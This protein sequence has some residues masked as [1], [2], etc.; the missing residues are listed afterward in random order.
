MII[1]SKIMTNQTVFYH[2]FLQYTR[3]NANFVD[4]GGGYYYKINT[5]NRVGIYEIKSI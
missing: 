1:N 3:I 5:K 2:Y 4:T